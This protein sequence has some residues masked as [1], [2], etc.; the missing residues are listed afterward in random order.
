MCLPPSQHKVTG[1]YDYSVLFMTAKSSRKGQANYVV[2]YKNNGAANSNKMNKD[3]CISSNVAQNTM[4]GK[5]IRYKVISII[6]FISI[7]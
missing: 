7:L 3:N 2:T 5:E 6:L 1:V 4:E